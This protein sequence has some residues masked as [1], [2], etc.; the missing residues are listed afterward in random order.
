MDYNI[1]YVIIESRGVYDKTSNLSPLLIQS[2]VQ[3]LKP[4]A[5]ASQIDW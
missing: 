1:T 5:H 3:D 4:H 2:I